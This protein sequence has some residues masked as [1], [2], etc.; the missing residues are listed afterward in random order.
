MDKINFKLDT[1]IILGGDFNVIFGTFL[2]ADG[3]SPSLKTNSLNKIITL[4]SDHDLCNI[5]GVRFPDTQRFSWRQK[6]PLIQRRLDYFF[7]SNEIQEDEA[8][9]DTVP[10]VASDHSAVHLKISGAKI[11]DKGRS[12]WKFNSSLVEDAIYIE[13]TKSLIN[14]V[15]A[16]MKDIVDLRVK[17]EFLKYTISQFTRYY[18]KQKAV[19]RRDRKTILEEKVRDLEQRIKSDS[20]VELLKEYNKVKKELNQIYDYITNG[21]ILRSRTTWYEEGEKSSSYFLRLEKGN[22]SKSHIRKLILDEN[23]TSEETDDLVILRELKSFYSSLHRKR[24]LKT[25]DECMEY[26]GNINTPKLQDNHI[27][28][29]EGKLTLKECWEALNSMKNNKSP[30]NDGFTKEFYVCFFGDLGSILVK[31]LNYSHGEGELSSSQKQAVITLIDKKDKDKRYIRNWRPISLLNVDLKIASKGLALRI[32]PVL[33][34]VIC[35]DQ[36]AYIKDRYIGESIRLVQDIIEYVDREEEKA[37]LFSTEIEKAFDSV[38]HN[39]IF[40]TLEK[41]GFGPEFIQWVKTLLKNGQ[42]CVMNNGNPLDI[43]ILKEVRDKVILSLHICL[44]WPLKYYFFK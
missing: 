40:A 35:H 31:T 30:G 15:N 25:E 28:R 21:I 17:W 38:N 7:I 13:K 3:G 12:N 44:S 22:K 37:I 11:K 33:K 43:L 29:C 14:T 34:N 10:S 1:K 8:F 32:K 19:G 4:L 39:F 36:I 24:S 27:E 18:A 5:F 9:I 20:N 2:D 42:S 6:N 16:E 26:S 41:F 23:D